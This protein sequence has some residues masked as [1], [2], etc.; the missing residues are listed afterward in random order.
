M[1]PGL[2]GRDFQDNVF[3]ETLKQTSWSRVSSG[4][5]PRLQQVQRPQQAGADPGFP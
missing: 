4:T 2:I 1:H 3:L 5:K